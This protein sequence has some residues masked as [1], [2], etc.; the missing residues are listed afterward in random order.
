[1]TT[2]RRAEPARL[3]H[4]QIVAAALALIDRSGLEAFSLREVA[5]M[6]GVYPTALYW[7][8][9]GGRN[10]LLAAVTAAAIQD[11]APP[12]STGDD[13]SQWIRTLLNRYRDALHRH[14]NVAPLLG[15]QLVSNAGVSPKLVEHALCALRSGGFEGPRLVNAYNAVIA[16]MLGYVTLELAPMPTDDP[17]GWASAFEKQVRRLSSNEHPVLSQ[18]V[19]RLAN[20]AFI[21]RWQSGSQVPLT[22]GFDTYVEMVVGGLQLI[23][24]QPMTGYRRR[25]PSPANGV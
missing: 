20:R 8:L 18:Y 3:T 12:F 11:V 15:A 22:G 19:D 25:R 1:M 21:L 7:H 24:Q 4:E 5:R 10:A 6:L 9:P 16:A 17:Q 13:W 2:R 23:A 14:P